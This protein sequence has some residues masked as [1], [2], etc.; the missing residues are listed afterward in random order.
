MDGFTKQHDY[1][2]PGVRSGKFSF[3]DTAQSK[4]RAKQNPYFPSPA[5]PGTFH[6][7]P[8]SGLQQNGVST[9][10]ISANS[11]RFPDFKSAAYVFGM[12]HQ[13]IAK[14][15]E[16]GWRL[17]CQFMV[18]ELFVLSFNHRQS[19]ALDSGIVITNSTEANGEASAVSLDEDFPSSPQPLPHI[20]SPIDP[21]AQQSS[22]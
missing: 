3:A 20:I 7:I 13:G 5:K 14:R 11:W 6:V 15:G 12:D 9:S 16:F 17:Q 22:M 10:M 4:H 19:F 21:Q 8:H 2:R 1:S 18:Y